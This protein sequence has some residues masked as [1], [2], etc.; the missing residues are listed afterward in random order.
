MAH[1]RKGLVNFD[2]YPYP[3]QS[4]V[5]AVCTNDANLNTVQANAP[6]P[7]RNKVLEVLI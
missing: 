6:L 5:R 4:I 2:L 7:L 1:P 3:D